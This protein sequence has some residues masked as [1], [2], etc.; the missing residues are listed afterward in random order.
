M[1]LH[2][3]NLVPAWKAPASAVVPLVLSWNDSGRTRDLCA[4][5][6][7]Q[8][9][10]REIG[11]PAWFRH[12]ASLFWTIGVLVRQRPNAVLFQNSFLLALLL[13]VYKT[14]HPGRVVLVADCHTKS[15]RRQMNGALGGV[16]KALKSWSLGQCQALVIATPTLGTEAARYAP[17]VLVIPD[18]LP[19]LPV[20]TS[21]DAQPA[22]ERS[23]Q[24][25]DVLVVGSFAVDEPLEEIIA[26]A[27][28]APDLDFAFTGKPTA[29][30]A[31][32]PMPGNVRLLGFL[33]DDAFA[34]RLGSA[35]VILALTR[36]QDCFM[37][38]ACEALSAHR[39]LVTSDT[40][41][42]RHFLADAAV[43]VK[44]EPGH[45]VDGLRAALSQSA[46][47]VDRCVSQAQVVRAAEHE[48]LSELSDVLGAER[49]AP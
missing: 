34:A 37:R 26:A 20:G 3:V 32:R 8:P 5:L 25:P 12:A 38:S 9:A 45:I 13:A 7:A 35:A 27:G 16:F 44:P 4:A 40:P 36:D 43:F 29:V 11:G 42:L 22:P 15:L 18:L 24:R 28:L 6:D 41:A 10:V 17:P 19:T 47:L 31:A 2:R 30:I 49:R 14:L 48:R 1:R 33:P 21:P 39:P 46:A 23:G